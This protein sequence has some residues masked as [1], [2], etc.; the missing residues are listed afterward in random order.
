MKVPIP[1]GTE[2]FFYLRRNLFAC[3]SPATH[4]EVDKY[5]QLEGTGVAGNSTRD[6]ILSGECD[7]L[8]PVEC[9]LD[10]PTNHLV[11]SN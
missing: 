5:F 7:S 11:P 2:R 6:G 9:Y 8:K 4:V 10:P 3:C 1:D